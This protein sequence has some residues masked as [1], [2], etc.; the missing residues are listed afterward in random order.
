MRL[1]F[2]EMRKSW[3]KIPL[4]FVLVL[5]LALNVY[6]F[7]DMYFYEGF[8]TREEM[9]NTKTAYFNVY[10]NILAG[11]I[12]P[13]KISY[14]KENKE[15][16]E[17]EFEAGNFSTEYDENRLTGYFFS[18][19][20]LFDNFFIPA[21]EY[22]VTYQNISNELSVS[23]YENIMFYNKRGNKSEAEK[24]RLIY[25]SYYGRVIKDYYLTEWAEVYFKYEFSC[26]LILLMVILGLSASFSSENESGMDI[27]IRSA[28]KMRK[29]V[30]AK[31]IS[32]AV[33]VFTLVVIFTIVDLLTVNYM[34][35]I[36][37]ITAPVY[38]A[39]LFRYSPFNFSFLTAIII[40]AALRFLAF[41][42]IAEVIMLI[43]YFTKN[44]IAST[45]ISFMLIVAMI[46]FAD[47]TLSPVNPINMLSSYK[48]LMQF[49]CVTI[50]GKPCLSIYT[51]IAFYLIITFVPAL[52]LKIITAKTEKRRN[53]NV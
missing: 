21:L 15:K 26:L 9:Q 28:G 29:T 1:L 43:S 25:N 24:N 8:W 20:G 46:I 16:L 53:K 18:D 41:F 12:T 52:I 30:N 11:E 19:L 2:Y 51:S 14:V 31:L 42:I 40:C 45:V 22:A 7:N 4:L 48:L 33:Y 10:D 17:M 23:A 38:T 5:L 49:D 6:R 44:T 3:L 37:G 32:A 36:D 47:G 39:E 35:R 34:C 27:M 13:E 50:F